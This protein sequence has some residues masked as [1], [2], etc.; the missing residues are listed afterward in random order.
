MKTIPLLIAALLAGCASKPL[1]PDW[2]ANAKGALDASV[3]DYLKGH[4]AASNA[5]F[6]EAN[7]SM[8]A[9]FG[10]E[11][12]DDCLCDGGADIASDRVAREEFIF[13]FR[14]GAGIREN[15]C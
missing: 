5:E 8:L 2:Q 11:K 15:F 13:L 14:I 12:S 6:R 1:P 9:G 4:T 10:F 7:K 3:D